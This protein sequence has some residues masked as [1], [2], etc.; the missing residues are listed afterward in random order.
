[1]I[2]NT[3]TKEGLNALKNNTS[4]NNSAFGYISLEQNSDGY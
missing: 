3:N 1:M 2:N 4:N